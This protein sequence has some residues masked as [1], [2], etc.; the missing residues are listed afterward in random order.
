M[1]IHIPVLKREAIEALGIEPG[2]AYVDATLG[3]GGHAFE[4]ISKMKGRGNLLVIDSSLEAIENFKKT[5]I[6]EG[7][8]SNS[9]RYFKKDLNVYLENDNFANFKNIVSKYSLNRINGILAD[10]GLSTDQIYAIPGISYMKEG[11]LDM[12]L[13]KSLQVKASDLLNGL[14]KK[15]LERLFKE[16]A[17]VEFAKELSKEIISWRAN[18]LFSTTKDLRDLIQKVVP[19]EDRK[20]TRKNPEAKVFQA[21][22]IAVNNELGSLRSF[23]PQAL[24]ALSPGGKIVIISFHSG[25]DRIVKKFIRD[26]QDNIQIAEEERLVRA[27]LSEINNNPRSSSAK[28]RVFSKKI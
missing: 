13:D 8:K 19:K 5:L 7:F 12:R 26:H 10:L 1:T 3:G 2:G 4:I 24:E 16:L 23:L 6:S 25:E 9:S 21:L 17:D 11:D 14:Y 15:E 22:R 28:M 27:S 20:G 18:K